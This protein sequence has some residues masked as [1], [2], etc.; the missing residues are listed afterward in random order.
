MPEDRNEKH[1][2]AVRKALNK[3]LD[4]FEDK[5]W[6]K[7]LADLQGDL[8]RKAILARQIKTLLKRLD[9]EEVLEALGRPLGDAYEDGYRMPLEGEGDGSGTTASTSLDTD[10]IRNLAK[11]MTEPLRKAMNSAKSPLPYVASKLLSEDERKALIETVIEGTARGLTTK[12]IAKL[13]LD[14]GI[15][16][17][18]NAKDLDRGPVVIIGGRPYPAD[19]YAEMLARTTTYWASNRGA[20]D[21]A[22]EAGVGTVFVAVSPG[23]I[24][25]CLDLEGKVYALNESA[26][27]KYEVPL[28]ADTPNGGPPWHPNCRHAMAGFVPRKAD[29]GKLPTPPEDS[30]QRGPDAGK[31]AEAA[32]QARLDADPLRYSRV[33]AESVALRGWGNRSIKLRGANADLAGQRIPGVV[34][35]K[36]H[37]ASEGLGALSE[38]VH[39]AKRMKDSGV[40]TRKE[41][42]KRLAD[43]LRAGEDKGHVLKTKA[44]RLLYHD[45]SS[46]WLAIVDAKDGQAVTV[47]P[48]GDE[49]WSDY[50]RRYK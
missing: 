15:V 41:L 17:A 18:V 11:T 14:R 4:G 49:K 48:L 6:K 27:S 34:G 29:K 43:T 44:G 7:D 12:K 19:R 16:K 20:M 33:I 8:R 10:R 35:R 9:S 3:A 36:E 31:K 1:A 21:R 13:L 39:L 30:L 46:G 22:E 26:A 50:E 42:R 23:S 2:E 45:P 40:K 32:F 28:L 25:F 47:Y 24:D 38:D 37:F 5:L